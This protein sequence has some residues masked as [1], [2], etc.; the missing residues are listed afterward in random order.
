MQ[1]FNAEDDIP[2]PQL[3]SVKDH[4]NQVMSDDSD[5]ANA[6]DQHFILGMDAQKA[7]GHLSDSEISP[8]KTDALLQ[9]SK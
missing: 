2:K 5:D 9:I 4:F 8:S 3:P 1:T 7:S 6:Q